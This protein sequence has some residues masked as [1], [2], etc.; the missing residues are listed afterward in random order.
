[1]VSYFSVQDAI[2]V[3]DDR[4]PN[5]QLITT[6]NQRSCKVETLDI[7]LPEERSCPGVVLVDEDVWIIGGGESDEF[8]FAVCY[9]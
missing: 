3:V 5:F 8:S 2:L 1:M 9:F 7:R 6:H 4:Q